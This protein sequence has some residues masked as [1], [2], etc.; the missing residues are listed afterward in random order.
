MTFNGIKLTHT[1][2]TQMVDKYD[3]HFTGVTKDGNK[4][5]QVQFTVTK[6]LT[7]NQLKKAYG[8]DLKKKTHND[9]KDGGIFYYRPSE[10]GLGVLFVVDNYRVV[11]VSIGNVPFT[12][13]K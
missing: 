11:A 5:N 10:K 4:A 8:K 12:T 6:D 1:T 7:L 3:Q 13:N 9:N 2:A